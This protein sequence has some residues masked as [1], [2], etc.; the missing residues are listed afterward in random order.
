MPKVLTELKRICKP[1]AIIKVRGPHFS[2]GVSWRDPDHKRLFS[3]FT[4]DY[5]SDYSFYAPVKFKIKSRKFNFT[6]TELTF[7]NP[8]INPI[9][10]AMPQ[11]Y[12]RFFCWLIPTAEGIVELEVVK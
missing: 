8:I 6:R 12:E 4:F 2:C 9:L 1:G 11:I 10:N 5:F 7:L 3:I